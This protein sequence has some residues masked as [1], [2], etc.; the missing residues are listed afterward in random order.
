MKFLFKLL[1]FIAALTVPV[2]AQSSKNPPPTPVTNTIAQTAKSTP[3]YAEILLR[4]TELESDVESMLVTY[5]EEYPKVK[6]AR[7]ELAILQKDL[8]KLLAVSPSDSGKLTLALGKLMIRRAEVGTDLWVKKNQYGDDY[9]EVKRLKK[10]LMTFDNAIK[11][12]L[13]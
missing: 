7:Y 4:K 5:T 10:K 2:F 3:A 11:E 13:P 6:E 9:P 12:I 8:D 1:F